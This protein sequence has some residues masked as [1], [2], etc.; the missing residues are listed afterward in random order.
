MPIKSGA[1]TSEFAATKW[2][3]I[4]AAL[5]LGLVTAWNTYYPEQQIDTDLIKSIIYGS[6]ITVGSYS[7]SRGIVKAGSQIIRTLVSDV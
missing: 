4:A 6:G 7:L 1:T 5:I 2:Y 3:S